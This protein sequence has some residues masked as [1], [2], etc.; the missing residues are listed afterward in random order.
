MEEHLQL[1]YLREV[2]TQCDFAL[3]AIRGLN[4]VLPRMRRDAASGDREARNTLH[5]EVF[6][7]IHSFLTHASNVSRIFWPAPPRRN[8]GESDAEYTARGLAVKRVARGV[9]LRSTTDLPDDHTLR[10][11]KLRDHLEHF[12]DRLDTWE[13]TSVRHNY[14]QDF[15]GPSNAIEGIDASDMMRW[16][17]PTTNYMRF[18]GEEFN[19]Q[20][21]ADAL[22]E[23]RGKCINAINAEETGARAKLL[24]ARG[25]TNVAADKHFSDAATPQS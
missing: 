6:R 17:D 10:N 15:I 22:M 23:I 9:A 21:L 3:N 13:S 20:A 18:R 4:N 14:V 25:L 7:S 16:F 8:K 11:R 24:A 2:V 5:Q 12:D 19:L 1:V